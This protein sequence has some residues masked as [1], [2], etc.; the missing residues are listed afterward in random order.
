MR[1][2]FSA[3]MLLLPAI[4]FAGAVE[5]AP[6]TV[7][8][9]KLGSPLS[10]EWKRT[11]LPA[12]ESLVTEAFL[13]RE[14]LDGKPASRK[15]TVMLARD[16]ESLFLFVRC[17][18][19]R[20]TVRS[21]LA[22]RDQIAGDDSIG[23]YLDTFRDRRRAYVFYVNPAGVQMDG[24]S[25]EGSGATTLSTR[26]GTRRRLTDYGYDVW[27]RIP[28]R[29][30][31]YNPGEESRWGIAV[32]RY[33]PATSEVDTWPYLSRAVQGFVPH[34]L[35]VA[36]PAE[37]GPSTLRLIPYTTWRWDR[38]GEFS[39]GLDAQWSIGGRIT[40][41]ATINPDYSHVEADERQVTRNQRF[42]VLFPERRPF[43]LEHADLFETP[44][45][46]FFSRRIQNPDAGLRV[47][48]DWGGLK[49]AALVAEDRAVDGRA[50][51][52][53][54]SRLRKD[55]GGRASLGGIW[56]EAEGPEGGSRLAGTDVWWKFTGTVIHRT[57]AR[58]PGCAFGPLGE[59]HPGRLELS[60]AESLLI[61]H[62]SI[63]QSRLRRRAWLH[64][65]RRPRAGS[66]GRRLP[67]SAQERWSPR[68]GP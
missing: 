65:A 33:S 24:I 4:A 12:G 66:P 39:A 19:K 54:V 3:M 15:T 62:L 68:L 1:P 27:M 49:L 46:A 59:R 25:A 23:L 52:V 50:Y 44:E 17:E 2:G 47:T 20:G 21:N 60:L 14:P 31:R 43:F 18:A 7:A 34:F 10:P 36:S 8:I 37:R 56:T 42:E 32:T 13:Q 67:L 26:F 30:L 40:I 11:G 9:P 35:P 5:P 57:V 61:H 51:R 41:D 38:R 16:S 29:S 6:A 45:T 48:G 55:F 58:E 28:F 64:A 53:A 22:P 63:P